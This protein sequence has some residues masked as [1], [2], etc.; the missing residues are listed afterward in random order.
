MSLPNIPLNADVTD[1]GVWR[2]V[3]RNLRS[4]VNGDW[5]GIYLPD[6]VPEP[7]TVPT[8]AVIYI[9]TTDGSL[10]VKFGSGTIKTIA[11]DP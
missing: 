5:P 7:N 2:N 6:G 3:L 1:K 4:V 10:K 9:D 8:K 11:T